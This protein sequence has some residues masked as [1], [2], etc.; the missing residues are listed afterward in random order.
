MRKNGFTLIELLVVVL[1]IGI[2][3]AVALPQYQKSVAK[4]RLAAIRPLLASIKQ[5]EEAY[6]IANQTYA[7]DLT[8][9]D[10]EHTCKTL[11]L[12]TFYCDNFFGIDPMNGTGTLEGNYI[13]ASYCPDHLRSW[14]DCVD[15]RDFIF[16][17]WF[18]NSALPNQITC[19][20]TTTLGEEICKSVQ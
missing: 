2:L 7:N 5:A 20:G 10:L 14:Y 8:L 17:V 16:Y 4:A 12:D 3:A 18:E 6:F 11:T 1:I 15:H 9:L 19:A 13:S